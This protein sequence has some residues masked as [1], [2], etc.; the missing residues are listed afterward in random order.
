M[1]IIGGVGI[2]PINY[3]KQLFLASGKTATEPAPEDTVVYEEVQRSVI[4]YSLIT[5][6]V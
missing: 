4:C 1:N 6:C 5:V 3:A 2:F